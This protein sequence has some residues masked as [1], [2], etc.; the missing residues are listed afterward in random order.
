[1]CEML[2]MR[3]DKVSNESP[4]LDAQCYKRGD[5]IVIMED[6]HPWSAEERDHP[7]WVLVFLP[8]VPREKMLA[9]LTPEPADVQPGKMLQRRA[10]TFSLTAWEASG[11]RSLNEQSALAL[12]SVKPPRFDPKAVKDA[13]DEVL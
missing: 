11:S 13:G 9:Y 4:H 12:K 1:M 6:G 5:V 10:C 2:V 7:R 3:Q 8:G